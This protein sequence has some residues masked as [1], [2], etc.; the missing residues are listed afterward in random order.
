MGRGVER[1]W[2][3]QEGRVDRL[4]R[5]RLGATKP[6]TTPCPR[7]ASVT[8]GRISPIWLVLI[9]I[10]S[11]QLGAAVAKHLFDR[12]EPT[13]LVWLRLVTSSVVLL[14]WARPRLRGRSRDDWLTM[15]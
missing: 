1:R 14:V 11:V 10:A 9:G 12:V 15:L 5:L 4:L 7:L 6:R 3:Q 2:W 13:A 8:R